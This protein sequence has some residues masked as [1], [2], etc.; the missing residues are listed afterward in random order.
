[1]RKLSNQE[2]RFALN[3]LKDALLSKPTA[4]RSLYSLPK[5]LDY[6]FNGSTQKME[7]VLLKI[8]NYNQHKMNTTII[9]VGG[10]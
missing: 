7:I 8:S 2:L 10:K 5:P 1:M 9:V 3:Y 6:A 4:V